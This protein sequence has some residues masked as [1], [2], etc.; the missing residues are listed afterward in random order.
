MVSS[1]LA[2]L[3]VATAF[4]ATWIQNAF[5]FGPFGPHKT[6]LAIDGLPIPLQE[7]VFMNVSDTLIHKSLL[8]TETVRASQVI[9]YPVFGTTFGHTANESVPPCSVSACVELPSIIDIDHYI[10]RLLALPPRVSYPLYT[11]SVALGKR[12]PRF[13]L[14]IIY[15]RGSSQVSFDHPLNSDSEAPA[16]GGVVHSK[17]RGHVIDHHIADLFAKSYAGLTT[18]PTFPGPTLDDLLELAAPVE[19]PEPETKVLEDLRFLAII[20][21]LISI[22]IHKLDHPRPTV[23]LPRTFAK[24]IRLDTRTLLRGIFSIELNLMSWL[25]LSIGILQLVGF[26]I[27]IGL[28]ILDPESVPPSSLISSILL[29]VQFIATLLR[30]RHAPPEFLVHMLMSVIRTPSLGRLFMQFRSFLF[31]RLPALISTVFCLDTWR[32]AYVYAEVFTMLC[33]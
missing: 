10:E 26:F 29:R 24:L 22:G 30:P 16:P 8:S 2:T 11:G 9:P 5:V 4:L 12:A 15:G 17:K 19:H 1:I 3:F 14:P 7:T 21:L 32:E 33:Q 25:G 6:L 27:K 31:T 20:L 23:S 13:F 28:L 18:F